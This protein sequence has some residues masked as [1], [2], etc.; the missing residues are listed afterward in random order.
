MSVRLLI[1]LPQNTGLGR[2]PKVDVIV[3]P[4][5]R[6]FNRFFPPHHILFRHVKVY[7]PAVEIS[8]VIL[9][10]R[11]FLFA[12]TNVGHWD[13][14]EGERRHNTRT[15]SALSANSRVWNY[16]HGP[17]DSPLVAG[18]MEGPVSGPL[19]KPRVEQ[20]VKILYTFLIHSFEKFTCLFYHG[21]VFKAVL[22]KQ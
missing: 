6:G 7:R 9:W 21:F 5:A 4:S 15:E 16:W 3:N 11:V 8:L 19:P 17:K 1:P 13:F 2:L 18:T 14:P 22:K 12:A 10:E 20:R